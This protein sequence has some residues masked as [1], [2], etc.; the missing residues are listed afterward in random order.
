[1]TKSLPTF[2][3]G[4]KI[5]ITGT[6]M[7]YN[8]QSSFNINVFSVTLQGLGNIHQEYHM[9]KQKYDDLGYYTNKKEHPKYIHSIGIVTSIDGAAL[10]DVLY[11]IKK[12][13]F[14]GKVI[15]KNTIAQGKDCSMSVTKAIQELDGQNLDAIIITRG[16]GSF[17]DLYGYS[18]PSVIEAIHNATT[19]TISAIGHETDFMLSDFVAD[20]RAPTPSLAAEYISTIN[21]YDQ[22][23]ITILSKIKKQLSHYNLSIQPTKNI[24]NNLLSMI[25]NKLKQYHNQTKNTYIIESNIYS[26]IQSKL[27]SYSKLL[28]INNNIQNNIVSLIHA[29]LSE[30]SITHI[31]NPISFTTLN[32]TPIT[33][34]DSHINKK[35][36]LSYNNC[37]YKVKLIK[38]L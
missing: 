36:I 14:N 19:Y 20:Y 18:N 37:L 17:E 9:L 32:N 26:Q 29:K 10:Q 31:Y 27:S 16:G 15:I 8:K 2:N 11:V 34:I 38:K 25:N 6:P 28:Q 24:Q 23:E 21:K 4:D 5:N 13:K 35:V 30:Y 3:N 12:N 33:D 1:M 7:F 22:L